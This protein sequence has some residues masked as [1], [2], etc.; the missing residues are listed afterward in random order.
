VPLRDVSA[1]NEWRDRDRPS[2]ATWNVVESW[3]LRLDLAPWL[4]P[5]TP[6]P[7][8]SFQPDFET[9]SAVVPESGGIEVFSTHD[10]AAADVDLIW[11]GRT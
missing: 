11:V 3:V 5:S 10:Y 2:P 1:L 8:L 4:Y 9:R 7:E 6:F